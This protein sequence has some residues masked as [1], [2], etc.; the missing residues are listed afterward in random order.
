M[1]SWISVNSTVSVYNAIVYGL[2]EVSTC[3]RS[4]YIILRAGKWDRVISGSTANSS[5]IF[6]GIGSWW[7][8][9][10]KFST[11]C[12]NFRVPTMKSCVRTC[13]RVVGLKFIFLFCPFDCRGRVSEHIDTR[14]YV[15]YFKFYM[16]T[17]EFISL[18][19]STL[20][21]LHKILPEK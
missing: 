7:F 3:W 2:R 16:L 11:I 13:I 4:S 12:V 5:F 21:S 8:L 15:N 14:V 17:V 6:A 19:R 18:F 1:Y 20:L 10:W 9:G